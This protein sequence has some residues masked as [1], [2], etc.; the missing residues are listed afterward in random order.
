MKKIVLF[1]VISL[2]LSLILNKELIAQ[3]Q[4]TLAIG[5]NMAY[6]S[7]WKKSE[8]FNPEIFFLKEFTS[9]KNVLVSFDVFYGEMPGSQ[10]SVVGSVFD[11]LNF[12]LKS[13]YVISKKNSSV[14]IGP[15]FRFRNEKKILYFYPPVNPFEAVIDPNKS[16]FD[17]GINACVIQKVVLSKKTGLLMKLSYSFHFNGVNPINLGIYYGWNW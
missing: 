7:D 1:T 9:T 12:N 16:H 13:N 5:S 15:S 4:N 2:Y 6:F 10:K 14:G 3:K 11:R 8:F 17:I